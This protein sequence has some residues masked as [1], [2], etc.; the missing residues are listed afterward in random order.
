MKLQDRRFRQALNFFSQNIDNNVATADDYIQKAY[1]LLFLSND[2][3]IYSEISSL[4][5]QAKSISSSN[6]NIYKVEILTNLRQ[7]KYRE[8]SSLLTEYKNKLS[9]MMVIDNNLPESYW[10]NA[11][12]FARTEYR[13]AEDMYAKLRAFR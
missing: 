12:S 1:C 4:L 6:I 7:N 3:S 10:Q 11:Y 5:N 2:P 13:W 8:A 9:E